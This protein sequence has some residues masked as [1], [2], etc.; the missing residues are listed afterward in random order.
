MQNG[1][2]HNKYIRTFSRD[3]V[4]YLSVVYDSN[5]DKIIKTL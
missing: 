3:L 4:S 5:G 1:S 2:W